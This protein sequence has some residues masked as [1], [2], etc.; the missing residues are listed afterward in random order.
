MVRRLPLVILIA[1]SIASCQSSRTPTLS[2][3]DALG[4]PIYTLGGDRLSALEA[5]ANSNCPGVTRPYFRSVTG[6][7]SD[8]SVSY[9]CE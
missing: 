3:S 6:S 5:T 9:T 4:K 2:G 1:I 7:G 8:M